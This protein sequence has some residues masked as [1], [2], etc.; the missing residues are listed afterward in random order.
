MFGRLRK[1]RAGDALG[2]M[3]VG[4]VV[5]VVLSGTAIAVTDNEFVYSTAQTG[6]LTIHPMALAP[7]NHAAA[8]NYSISWAPAKLT[9]GNASQ[10]FNTGVNLP[11]QA[12]ISRVRTTYS[13]GISSDL[14]VYLVRSELETNT[15]DYLVGEVVPENSESRRTVV[16]DTR[17][18]IS[19]VDNTRYAFGFGV[20]LGPTTIFEGARI[21]YQ[22]RRA[23]D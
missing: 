2:L 10:C 5:T 22:Y 23:G 7:A 20:C 18:A 15:T 6:N 13:S 3:L 11:Q 16:H 1:I 9:R 14:S 21:T 4:V 17:D 19:V 12:K 8:D